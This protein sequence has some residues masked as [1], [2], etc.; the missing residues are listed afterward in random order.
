VAA[1]GSGIAKELRGER[2]ADEGVA[3]RPALRDCLTS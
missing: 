1:A 2:G 3:N